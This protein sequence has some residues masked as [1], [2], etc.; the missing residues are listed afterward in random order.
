[1]K[2]KETIIAILVLTFCLITSHA[3]SLDYPHSSVNNIGCDSCHFVYGTQS[4]LM[5]EWT[6]HT[7]QNIDDTQYNSLC[8]SCHNDVD[9]P[10]VRTHSSLNIDNG[11]GNWTM[12]CITCH[13]QHY[14]RQFRTYG[15]PSYLYQ[16]T[17]SSVTTTTLT[18]TG[19]G[20][21][22]DQYKDLVV[23]PNIAQKNYNYKITGNTGDTLTI[24][25]PVDLT[26][27]S[28]GNTFAIVYGK[29]IRSTVTTP[30]SGNK[31]VKFYY[32]TGTNSFADGDSTY[33]GVCEACH[34][35]TTYHKNSAAGNHSHNSGVKCTACHLHT[36]GFRHNCDTCHGYP[37]VVN[38]V[39]GPNGLASNNGTTGSS[40]AGAHDLHANTKGYACA[41]CHYNSAGL[42]PTHNSSLTITMG[43][44]LFG[45][46]Y[47]G[48]TYNGQSGVSYNTSST[49]PVTMVST[50][51]AKT[52]SNLYCHSTGQSTT[53]GNSSTP[54]YA[55]PV[56]DNPSSVVCGTC[57]KVSA[58]SGLNSGSHSAHLGATGVS[59][60][61]DC[62]TGASNDASSY[63]SSNHVNGSIDA[64]NSYTADGTP[65]NGYGTCSTASCHDDGTGTLT[66]TPTW[67]TSVTDCSECHATIPGTGSHQKHVVTTQYNKSVCGNCHNGAVQ[68]S[69]A[70]AQHRDGNIDVY[71][72]TAGD[73]GYPQDKTKGSAF[74]T[75][76]TAYC[77]S[78]GQSTTN[79]SSVTPT[80]AIPTWGDSS[81]ATCGTCHKVTKASGL[82][83]GS[84]GA[85]LG[86]TGVNGCGDCHTGASN[87]AS[88][89]NSVNHV[90]R[91]IEVSNSYSA[92]G[93]P[94]NG[95]GT[96]ST[97]SCH[98]NGRGSIVTTPAWGSSPVACTAC[99]AAAPATGSHS[100]HLAAGGVSCANCHKGA[101]QGTT[102]PDQHLDENIDVYALTSGDLGYLQNKTKGSAFST[103]TTAYCHS[104]G[105]GT[106]KTTPTWGSSGT[107]CSTCHNAL[108]TSGAHNAHVKTA[109]I[110]YGSTAVNNT[111]TSVD[112]GCGNCHPVDTANH[113]NGTLNITLNK[114]HGGALKSKNGVSDD[115]SGYS[116]TQGVSVTCS[117]AYCHS[118]GNG[119]FDKTS[120]N[121]YGGSITDCNVC[122]GN[123]TYSDYR[124]ATPLYTSGSPKGNAHIFHTSTQT[125]PS[126][127]IQCVNCHG[128]TT[129]TNTSIADWTK[130]VNGVYDV[131]GG[132]TYWDFGSVGETW[133]GTDTTVTIGSYD[134]GTKKC[135]NVSC[136]PASD[137]AQKTWSAT[138]Y[139]CTDCHIIDMTSPASYHHA[140]NSTA[141]DH[142]PELTPQ[143]DATTGENPDHRMC[144]MCHVD[145]NIFSPL[146]NSNSTNRANVLRIGINVIPDANDTTTFTNTDFNAATG[147]GICVSCHQQEILKDTSRRMT[148]SHVTRTPVITI[149][150]YTN[151]KHQYAVTSRYTNSGYTFN[152][153]CTKCHDTQENESNTF[154][155]Q[156]SGDSSN[157][158]RFGVHVGS[159]R[160]LQANLGISAPSETEEEDLC[161]RCHSKS[162]DTNPGGGTA[163]SVANRDYYNA[164]NMSTAAQ[165]IFTVMQTTGGRPASSTSTTD[166]LYFKPS[167]TETPSEPMPNA[168]SSGDTFQ[169]GTWIG[170]SMSPWTTSTNY[171]SYSQSLSVTT[172][173]KNWGAI[174]FTS[175]VV[176]TTTTV[177]AGNWLISI[178]SRESS[179]S[180]NANIRYMIYKWNS[181]DT[182]GTTL[183][184][185]ATHAMEFSTAAAPGGL[186]SVSIPVA[187]SI[188]LN[189]GE[190]ISVD[191]EIQTVSVTMSGTYTIAYYFGS[192]ATGSLQLP[193]SVPFTYNDPGK[194]GYGHNVSLYSG[195]H[196]PSH[197]DE[198][199]DYISANKHVECTDCHNM[200]AAGSAK[201]TQGTNVVSDIL[202]GVDGA[203]ISANSSTLYF[204]D[205]IPATP[206][207][208][209]TASTDT[210]QGGTWQSRNMLTA[211]G[212]AAQTQTVTINNTG[213]P[214]YWRMTSF[215]SPA[216][217]SSSSISA[218]NWTLRI[219]AD[220]NNAGANAYMR[221]TIYVW[222]ANNTKGTVIVA[223]TSYGSELTTTS[224][225]YSWTLAGGTASLN[226]GDRVV[227][228]LE[229]D[230]RGAT[231]TT[232]T[233]TY[234]WNGSGTTNDSYA[235]M[236]N[237]LPFSATLTNWTA[238]TYILGSATKAYE[239]CYK[240]HSGANTNVTNWGGT[241]AAAWTDVGLDFNLGNKSFHP[242]VAAL[243]SSGSGSSVLSSTAL[244]GGWT[245]GQTMYCTDCHKT[246][247]ANSTGPHGSSVKWM[248]GGTN[249][250]WPYTLASNNGTSSGTFRTYSNRATS[251]N[252]DDGLFCLNC[253]NIAVAPHTSDSAHQSIPCVGCHIRVPHGGKVSR[254][255]SATNSATPLTVLPARLAPDGNGGG[256]VYLRKFTKATGSYSKSNCYS[257][258]SSCGD[259]NSSSNGSESW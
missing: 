4:T 91:L 128:A 232:Y 95:Y 217:S 89:Y 201:H 124:K 253:H 105:L 11:Y 74:T 81:S 125:T 209:A 207:P 235:T 185:A 54:T 188:T 2:K 176:A 211:Q 244:A 75:C 110:A 34:T 18:R 199:L 134:Q 222:N 174:T 46:A 19:A 179:T 255:I 87:D 136:H 33:N 111:T 60:C 151:A 229:I 118:Q 101:V 214:K 153:N 12:E 233:A 245:P 184:A 127:E 92:A 240:C 181:N 161:F 247:S 25:G 119:D 223:P 140:M 63:N 213:N 208:T 226:T 38:T 241:G 103:C 129:T 143:G 162:T 150:D 183:I 142:Y 204:R 194:T 5:P 187:S 14:Q 106:Y 56:W 251:Q 147:T 107:G 177:P 120:P 8:W 99:H 145:H 69:T 259:H 159:I 31:S 10:Y 66:V 246:N 78:T 200:H 13:D 28:S 57:H 196:K 114:N 117:A 157:T 225:A 51:G 1:M 27:A 26:K 70:P 77:H 80:Y 47:Q 86:A 132:G 148:E 216:V 167:G 220:E 113:R 133:Y 109:A 39:G 9:A 250:A 238:P 116:Q 168:H 242:V 122:H 42:G 186:R 58:A 3:Y 192:G 126:N 172:G 156:Y 164:T 202:R 62:H 40:T 48:G 166:R 198:T 173:T 59:G 121:W 68:G 163:K 23:V 160:R 189:A 190:K 228:E 93:T 50:T 212:S 79:G 65:G 152:A 193:G 49:S 55:T 144:L 64:A 94:G 53:D 197:D 30:N 141:A 234:R 97:A 256:T 165:D 100:I 73:L 243:N 221:A 21:T 178:Y 206:T 249:K 112:L 171:E 108:P 210:F 24:A 137:A 43:F 237:A 175:P 258:N 205:T 17:V 155:G 104:N 236:P 257:S 45:G 71:A 37:P 67:G 219:W 154:Q 254:L 231:A 224:A 16:G 138:N 130:H 230:S 32:S 98:D 20:W 180:A 123:A 169:G 227:V 82:T 52:C 83:S 252:T 61:G 76:T 191:I 102:A 239:I 182:K 29:L 115:T 149:S 135:M 6:S 215:I 158:N 22:D 146:L 84:H 90:D 15:S 36:K 203:V 218:G 131:D 35:Q 96:C 248:L 195:L 72:S 41:T 88:L 44:S 85:H 139:L 170:R 7:Q